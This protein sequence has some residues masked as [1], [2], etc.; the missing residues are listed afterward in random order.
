MCFS[1]PEHRGYCSRQTPTGLG[2]LGKTHVDAPTKQTFHMI[3]VIC[4]P[5]LEGKL[6]S[7]GHS[8]SCPCIPDWFAPWQWGLLRGCR[9][10]PTLTTMAH[11]SPHVQVKVSCPGVEEIQFMSQSRPVQL[12][13]FREMASSSN[14]FHV[15][16]FAVRT[17]ALAFMMQ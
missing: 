2:N 11:G 5:Y 7:V 12:E 15:S 13:D 10:P 1:N 4:A 14:K 3:C 9:E 17:T 16:I 8:W 6:P